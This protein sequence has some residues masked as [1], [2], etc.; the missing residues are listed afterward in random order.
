MRTIQ[1]LALCFLICSLANCMTFRT[2]DTGSSLQ[3]EKLTRVFLQIDVSRQAGALFDTNKLTRTRIKDRLEEEGYKIVEQPGDADVQLDLKFFGRSR[4]TNLLKALPG[5]ITLF[6]LPLYAKKDQYIVEARAKTKSGAKSY[7]VSQI[8]HYNWLWLLFAPIAFLSAEPKG[9]VEDLGLS[10][11]RG[12]ENKTASFGYDRNV[13]LKDGRRFYNV[14][15]KKTQT[16]TEVVVPGGAV[17]KFDRDQ[18]AAET[19]AF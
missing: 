4:R 9:T 14:S 11:L 13:V 16:G 19:P 17:L 3:G 10:A 15:V 1:S 12:V 5:S 18:I 6:I 8:T 7:S 2:G